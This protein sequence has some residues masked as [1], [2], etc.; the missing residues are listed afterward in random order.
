VAENKNTVG[1]SGKFILQGLKKT[2]KLKIFDF[3]WKIFP[4]P[5]CYFWYLG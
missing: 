4:F 1:K 2:K 5:N 3:F